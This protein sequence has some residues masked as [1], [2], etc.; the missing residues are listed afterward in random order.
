MSSPD[1]A[2]KAAKQFSEKYLSLRP[3]AISVLAGVIRAAY[4]CQTEELERLRGK[5]GFCAECERLTKELDAA[6]HEASGCDDVKLDQPLAAIIAEI[7]QHRERAETKLS[8]M[9]ELLWEAREIIEGVPRCTT[10]GC[11]C[12]LVRKEWLARY[13]EVL[14]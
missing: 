3:T 11:T 14:K 13:K 7:Q 1:P 5:T 8:T 6:R 2:I 9:T 10:V 12:Y 4:Q